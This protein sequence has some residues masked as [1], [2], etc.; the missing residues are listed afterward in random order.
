MQRVYQLQVAW[1]LS[2]KPR[3]APRVRQPASATPTGACG[4]GKV[5]MEVTRGGRRGVR[6]CALSRGLSS[7]RAR[8]C[9]IPS[10][11]GIFR[12]SDQI[13]RA[14]Q[15]DPAIPCYLMRSDTYPHDLM[16]SRPCFIPPVRQN[17]AGPAKMLG[18]SAAG[19]Q[20]Q[21]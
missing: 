11:A 19:P 3:R 2:R 6:L 5:T 4:G 14:I 1:P 21:L 20:P 9:A 16:R 17:A 13:G 8:V 15:H 7:P 12:G 10:V 18:Q